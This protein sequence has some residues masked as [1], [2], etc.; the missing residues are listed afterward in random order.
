MEAAEM[1]FL[2]RAPTHLVL[3]NKSKAGIANSLY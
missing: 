3:G 1:R 2:R